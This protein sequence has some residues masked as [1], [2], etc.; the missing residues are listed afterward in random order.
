MHMV[1]QYQYQY[2]HVYQCCKVKSRFQMTNQYARVYQCC[3]CHGVLTIFCQLR[4]E[5][6]YT[7]AY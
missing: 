4:N 5:Y 3:R 1:Y 7:Y 2:A 6:Q